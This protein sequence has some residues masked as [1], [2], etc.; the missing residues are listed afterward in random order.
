M[1]S[2]VVSVPCDSNT[3]LMLVSIC[4]KT[5]FDLRSQLRFL[6]FISDKL[7]S[8]ELLPLFNL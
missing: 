7:V 2:F 3:P 6:H 5:H 1:H 8:E 4:D